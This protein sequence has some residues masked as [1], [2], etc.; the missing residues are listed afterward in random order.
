MVFIWGRKS[1]KLQHHLKLGG[2]YTSVVQGFNRINKG[3]STTAELPNEPVLRLQQVDGLGQ[4]LLGCHAILR[5][6]Q[7]TGWGCLVAGNFSSFMLEYWQVCRKNWQKVENCKFWNADSCKSVSSHWP[8]RW[9]FTL[10]QFL[11]NWSLAFCLQI[12]LQSIRGA[13]KRFIPFVLR[14]YFLLCNTL[15]NLL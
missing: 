7:L 12:N 14:Q 11:W 8:M 5:L 10:W 3:E 4:V 9:Q 1:E 15:Q 13:A 2:T 6:F